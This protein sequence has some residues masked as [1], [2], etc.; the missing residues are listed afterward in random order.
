VISNRTPSHTSNSAFSLSSQDAW[1]SAK[2]RAVQPLGDV[3]PTTAVL[4]DGTLYVVH[5]KLNELIA[6]PPEQ[7]AR[8]RQ[9]PTIRA[10]A[11]VTP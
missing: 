8:L 11:R 6:V 1:S 4:R 5:S 9:E 2:L 3:Y 10:I 7:K